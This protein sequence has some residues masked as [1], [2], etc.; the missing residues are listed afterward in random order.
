M[1]LLQSILLCFPLALALSSHQNPEAPDYPGELHCGLQSLQFTINLSQGTATPALIAWDNRGLPHRL[2]NDSGCGIWLREGPGSS[3]VLEASYGGCYVTEWTRMTQSPGM[4]RP[5]APPSGVTPQD[6]HYIMLLGVEEADVAGRSMVTK[7]KMLKCPTDP[8]DTTLLSSLSYSPLQNVALDAPNADLCDSVPVWDRL[9]CAPSPITQGDCEKIGCCYNLE[10]SSCYYGNTVTS[11]CTQDGHFS[12]AVSRKVTSPPLLLN[13]VRLARLAFRN[14]HECTPVMATR[15][16]ALFW[17]SFNSCGT[18]RQI[19]GDQAL[20]ENELV[21]AR[22]VRTWSHGSITRDSIFRLRV[23]CS[24]SISSNASPVNVQVF[25]LPPPH[26]ETQAGPL[27][28]E[29]KIAKDKLYG[30][31]YTAGDYPV[32]K[33]LRDPIYVEVSIRHRTDPYLGLLLHHCWAT[34]STNP[35]H[36]PQWPMLVKGCP[37]AGDNYQTQ[38]IP[39]QKAL[40]PPFPSYYQRFSIFTFSFVDSVTKKA[41]GGP[42]YLHCSASVCQPAGTP[43]CMIT[44]PVARRRRN[45]NIHFHNHTASISSKGPMI[46]LQATK[47]SSEK[48]HKNSSSPIDSQ[49]LWMAGL[50]GTLITGALLV[51]YLAIRKWR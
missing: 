45:S 24:Y 51:S 4:L 14:D 27:T 15:T 17:F 10:A 46:L 37:Y 5:P 12:I 50:S 18:T 32:V 47:D 3:M 7:T 49:A 6:H 19:I 9:P 23:S 25:T 20:Y 31:Y 36:Q 42:V 43:S 11:H 33:L 39:V 21:A 29:L 34:P 30:S 28:L 2:Q 8:P 41:L 48:L 44:C 38:L 16:F 35:Q 1:W 40:D 13:S 22:D 26:P